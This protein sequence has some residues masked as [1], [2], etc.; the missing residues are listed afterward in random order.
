MKGKEFMTAEEAEQAIDEV[1][2]ERE[3]KKKL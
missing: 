1:A 2:M 3:T